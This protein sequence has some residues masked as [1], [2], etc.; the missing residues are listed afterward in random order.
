MVRELATLAGRHALV[1]FSTTSQI[2]DFT[3]ISNNRVKGYSEIWHRNPAGAPVL[4]H[5]EVVIQSAPI[6][7]VS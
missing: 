2:C 3:K 7:D 6:I 4:L 5:S 1:V